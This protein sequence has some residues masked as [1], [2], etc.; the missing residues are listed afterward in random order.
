MNRYKYA[1]KYT[2][3]TRASN[4]S[5]LSGRYICIRQEINKSKNMLMIR[6]LCFEERAQK[7]TGT[8]PSDFSPGLTHV[9]DYHAN[10][11]LIYNIQNCI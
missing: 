3:Q 10:R 4:G 9:K 7:S 1:N 8:S 5:W 11:T 6:E 2:V